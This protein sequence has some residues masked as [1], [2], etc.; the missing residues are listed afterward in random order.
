M[1]FLSDILPTGY[2]AV[3]NTGVGKG[4]SLAIFGAGPVGQMAAASAR[5]LGIEKIFMVDHHQFRLDFARET[6]GVIPINFD[7]VDAADSS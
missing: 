3:V 4:G 1:L 2:Q 6:Y 7:D 5:M